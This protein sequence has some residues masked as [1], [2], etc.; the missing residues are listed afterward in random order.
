MTINS[1][2][3]VDPPPAAPEHET[4]TAFLDYHRATLVR[5]VDGLSDAALR[6][7]IVPSGITLLGMI[8]H[9]AHVERWWFHSVFAD[10]DIA[11]PWT[12]ADPD[13]DWRIEPGETAQDMLDLYRAAVEQ[14]RRIVSTAHL[15]DHARKPG[16]EEYTLRW[17]VVHMI[18]ET[19]RHNGHADIMRELS[20]G[21]T[22]E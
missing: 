20:D 21:S 17:I 8:K 9:L 15:D 16:R 18:E 12:D 3:R 14:S 11:F 2:E 7:S 6:H 10:Q 22:G 4:L 5:K 19:A 1:F 13:A